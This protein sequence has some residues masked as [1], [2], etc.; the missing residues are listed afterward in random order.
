MCWSVLRLIWYPAMLL[1][2][3]PAAPRHL[4]P[5][6][7]NFIS[8]S[9]GRFLVHPRNRCFLSRIR[10]KPMA[11]RLQAPSLSSNTVSETSSSHI[12]EDNDLLIVGPGVLGRMV[13]EK[14]KQDYPDC[15][16]AGQTMTVDHH[17]ELIE[18]GINPSLKGTT[19]NR[20]YANII[21][22]A[23]PRTADYPADV[24]ILSTM[25]WPGDVS[26][27][28]LHDSAL[29]LATSNWN[30]RG[31]FL[32]TSSTAV[33]D[34]NDNGL[35]D[36]DCPVVP[37][38]KIPRVDVLLKAE[39][40]VLE[41]GGY[42]GAHVYWIEKGVVDTRPDC[43][44]NLIH[45]EDAASL[46]AAIM[47]RRF[48]GQI[49]LGCDNHP[50]SRRR[51]SLLYLYAVERSFFLLTG[52][53]LFAHL[54]LP[55]IGMASTTEAALFANAKAPPPESNHLAGTGRSRRF[56]GV[57]AL[58]RLLLFATT[59]PALVVLATSKQTITF[60]YFIQPQIS[61]QVTKTGKFSNSPALIYL[62]VA[63]AVAVAYSVITFIISASFLRKPPSSEALF[64]L[65]LLDTLM[66]GIMASA[67]GSAG[68]VSYL[69]VKGNSHVQWN[70]ICNKFD[71]FCRYVGCS[72]IL[73]LVASII[74]VLLIFISTFS[75]YR[76]SR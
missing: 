32:F 42:R 43:I 38:G 49:F 37:I 2:P 3:I 7:C 65:I 52:H 1:L 25:M 70:K 40:T 50:L 15:W 30:G 34:C 61:I 31:S 21:F 18:L 23:P 58:L 33:Y 20:Q 69:G 11:Q 54:F 67:T 46:A 73:T 68:A 19:P 13:A 6:S 57:V 76:R 55:E 29:R 35:C 28:L 64:S 66:A 17:D 39:G 12:V 71:K 62:L 59:V 9:V 27:K 16:I 5:F 22:C 41:A 45:Y 74:L 53:R 51:T 26:F 47:K 36:E 75:L 60:P 44:V 4:P 14:W 56:A 10:R 63:L 8:T 72:V 24:N 48:R